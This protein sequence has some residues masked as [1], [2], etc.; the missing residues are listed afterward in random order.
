MTSTQYGTETTTWTKSTALSDWLNPRVFS[1]T[2][3]PTP[4]TTYGT[5]SGS[6]TS[7]VTTGRANTR[8]ADSAS[9]AR[10]PSNVA[11]TPFTAASAALRLT[12][13]RAGRSRGRGGTSGW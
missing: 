12:A 10:I 1:S 11:A 7:A 9:A 8:G 6:I 3:M 2:S 5:T 4:R 13:A